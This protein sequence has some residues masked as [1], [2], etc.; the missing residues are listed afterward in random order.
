MDK[1][2]HAD[3]GDIQSRLLDHRP[4]LQGEIRYFLREFEEKRGFREC[5]LLENLNK[6][7]TETEEQVLPRCTKTMKANLLDALSCLEA[8]NHM[9][10]RIQQMELETQHSIILQEGMEKRKADWEDFLKEQARLKEEVDEEH[11]KAV[12]RLSIQYSEMKKDLAKFSH[13]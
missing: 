13:F 8:V 3:V 4:V 12:G 7:V 1:I 11:A 2:A 10:Q 5:R 9:M 6:L